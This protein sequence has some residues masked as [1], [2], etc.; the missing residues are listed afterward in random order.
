MKSIILASSSVSRK[1]QLEVLKIP[2]TIM[3]PHVNEEYYHENMAQNPISLC[4]KL[5]K[6]KVEAVQKEKVW[7][8][9]ADQMVSFKGA[10]FGKPKNFLNAKKMLST[11]QGHT[12]ELI[13][14]LCLQKPDGSFFEEV[15]ISKMTLRELSEAQ[16]EDYLK[17]E[18]PYECAGS[19]KVEGLGISLFQKIETQEFTAIT[20]LP[21]VSLC[22]HLLYS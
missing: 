11:L 10:V 7:V 21:M 5:A 12:H 19:Y 4:K 20:G 1:K 3:K 15:V 9:G 16:I 6:L 17:K 14:A 2:F 13:T 18:Q 8:I 22:S